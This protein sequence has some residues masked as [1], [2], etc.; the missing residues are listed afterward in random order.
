M[1]WIVVKN[2]LDL[3]GDVIFADFVPE[4]ELA[5]YYSGGEV[6]VLPSLYEGFGFPPLEAIACSCPVITSNASSLP[7]VIGETGNMVNPYDTD[8]LAQAELLR[9][10]QSQ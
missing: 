4:A 2:A 7:E 1:N 5:A 10:N 8:S 9:R 6:F 3:V